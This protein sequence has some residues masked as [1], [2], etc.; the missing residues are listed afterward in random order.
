M[1]ANAYIT[2]YA[3]YL[4]TSKQEGSPIE[5][6]ATRDIFLSHISH[7]SSDHV[8]TDCQL[9]KHSLTDCYERVGRVGLSAEK[10]HEK[11]SRRLNNLNRGGGTNTVTTTNSSGKLFFKG[12]EVND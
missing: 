7:P 1:I 9:N 5:A 3:E 8:V 2:K 10:N 11:A 12:D 6:N 4:Q